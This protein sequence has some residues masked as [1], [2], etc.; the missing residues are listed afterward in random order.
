MFVYRGYR[1]SAILNGGTA[2]DDRKHDQLVSELQRR[3]HRRCIQ[4]DGVQPPRWPRTT[5]SLHVRS[6]G[7]GRSPGRLQR[8]PAAGGIPP[9]GLRFTGAAATAAQVL[10]V[11]QQATDDHS[12]TA[13]PQE[14]SSATAARPVHQSP[15]RSARR[16][17]YKND[18]IKLYGCRYC[19]VDDVAVCNI[20]GGGGV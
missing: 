2:W 19:Y 5:A 10:R 7:R 9:C 18:L 16:Y 13:E 15:R 14:T 3:R 6:R 20:N 1:T 17:L 12:R 11:A 4:P 8:W